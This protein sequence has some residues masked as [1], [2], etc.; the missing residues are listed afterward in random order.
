MFSLM[1]SEIVLTLSLVDNMLL[2]S[3]SQ[4]QGS[5]CARLWTDKEEKDKK[6]IQFQKLTV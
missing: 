5:H 6:L 1:I 3:P 2:K 4:V